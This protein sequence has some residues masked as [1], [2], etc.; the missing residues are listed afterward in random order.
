MKGI[1]ALVYRT[2][3]KPIF[4]G[5]MQENNLRAGTENVLAILSFAEALNIVYINLSDIICKQTELQ[6]YLESNLLKISN[7]IIVGKNVH[8]LSNTTCVIL[9]GIQNDETVSFFSNHGIY[10]SKGAACHSGVWEPSPVLLA[11]GYTKEEAECC[12][13]ISI[14]MFSTKEEIDQFLVFSR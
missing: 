6:T 5:G 11:M 13:R 8:R 4:R 1:G 3:P 9:Q 14:G 12:V 10:I 7:C 2:K